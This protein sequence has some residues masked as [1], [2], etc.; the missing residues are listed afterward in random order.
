MK[1]SGLEGRESGEC[2]SLPAPAPVK[3]LVPPT[4]EGCEP[5][6]GCR[7]PARAWPAHEGGEKGLPAV[8]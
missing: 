7:H 6:G 2:R 3:G 1:G 5:S 4:P 8:Q